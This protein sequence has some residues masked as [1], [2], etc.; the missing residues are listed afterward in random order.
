MCKFSILLKKLDYE[1]TPL[2][3]E[4]YI[5][6]S[7]SSEVQTIFKSI[8]YTEK[9]DP[10]LMKVVLSLTCRYDIDIHIKRRAAEDRVQDKETCKIRACL[11]TLPKPHLM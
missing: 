3:L 4:K 11:G 2:W 7:T 9:Y 6:L 10:E 5:R 1:E 8:Y